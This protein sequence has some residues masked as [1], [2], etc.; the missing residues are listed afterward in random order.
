MF[1]NMCFIAS[2]V[3]R[4]NVARLV[5]GYGTIIVAFVSWVSQ[6]TNAKY[7]WR[8]LGAKFTN[9]FHGY[10]SQ[11]WNNCRYNEGPYTITPLMWDSNVPWVDGRY[12][13][14]KFHL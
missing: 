12:N 2:Y 8:V 4:K 11:H 7:N 1:K 6:I 3:G 5:I 14:K 10:H 9:G 13:F